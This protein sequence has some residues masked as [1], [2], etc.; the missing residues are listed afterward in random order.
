MA[1]GLIE[2]ATLG[3]KIAESLSSKIYLASLGRRLCVLKVLDKNEDATLFFQ[4]EIK[5]LNMLAGV[6][7]FPGL[8]DWQVSSGK[9]F[10]L[11]D[12]VGKQLD[13][14]RISEKNKIKELLIQAA[15]ALI[16]L[17]SKGIIHRDIKPRN[18]LIDS[19]GK[20]K[21]IDFGISY[22]PGLSRE[23]SKFYSPIFA[24][25]EQMKGELIKESDI[26]SLGWTFIYLFGAKFPILKDMMALDVKSRPSLQEVQQQLIGEEC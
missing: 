26:Y 22:A 2:N 11:F 13:H 12:Y 7:I 18:I 6:D 23:I 20:A 5:L 1:N 4:N 17:H 21:I 15:D 3:G 24:A 10:L 25:P 8:V 16:Y 19:R 14:H 9:L